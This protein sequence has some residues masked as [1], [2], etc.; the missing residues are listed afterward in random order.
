MNTKSILSLTAGTLLTTGAIAATPAPGTWETTFAAGVD[1][2]SRETMLEPD[3]K[4]LAD[5][6]TID[7]TLGG[8]SGSVTLDHLSFHHALHPGP[9]FAIESGYWA[10]ESFEPFVRFDYAQLR[11]RSPDIG[12]VSSTALA[13]N[14]AIGADFDNLDEQSLALGSRY[15]FNTSGAVRP[16]VT[17]FV[18]LAHADKLRADLEATG[19]GLPSEPATL[20]HATTRFDAGLGAGVSY[21]ISD[22]T[23]LRFSADLDYLA[24]GKTRTTA[25][26]RFGLGTVSVG[27]PHWSVPVSLGMSYRF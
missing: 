11:G 9:Q 21:G 15:F 14:V 5:L 24:G 25:F 27:A 19:V 23:D 10:S 8:H 17:E 4:A 3:V 6:G 12:E 18:G 1:G 26:D 7:P 20:L 2:I 22:R 13:S 16:Y